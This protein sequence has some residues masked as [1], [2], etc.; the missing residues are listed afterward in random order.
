MLTCV[1]INIE[2]PIQFPFSF[3]FFLY[4]FFSLFFFAFF[5]ERVKY[6]ACMAWP[7]SAFCCPKIWG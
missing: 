2:N 6:G 7:A 5:L 4:L 3:Y 1:I